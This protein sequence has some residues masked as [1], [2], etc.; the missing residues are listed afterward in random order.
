M[1]AIVVAEDEET[2]ED[3]DEICDRY[4]NRGHSGRVILFTDVVKLR[5]AGGMQ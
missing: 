2:A 1:F 3:D 4:E 5:C